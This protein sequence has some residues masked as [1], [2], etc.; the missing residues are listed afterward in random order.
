MRDDLSDSSFDF[1]CC[2]KDQNDA[3]NFQK[4]HLSELLKHF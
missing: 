1:N 4:E 2:K 3:V